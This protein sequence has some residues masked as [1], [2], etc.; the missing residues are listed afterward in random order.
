[1]LFSISF[2]DVVV[3]IISGIAMIIF[4]IASMIKSKNKIISWQC[5]G[6]MIF[7]FVETMTKAWSSIVQ[8]VIGITRNLLTITKKNTKVISILLIILGAVIGVAVNIIF[9]PKDAPWFGSWVGYLPVVANLEYSII[10]L[11]KNSTVRTIK[12]S[13]CISSILWGLNFLF[14]GVY[15]SAILNFICAITALI[16]FFKFKNNMN[17]EEEE[18]KEN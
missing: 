4:I 9:K 14:L 2:F 16:S 12:L 6:H 5:I 18:V 10:V 8:E 17:I 13:F 7:V 11:R 3:N 15:V 1:M